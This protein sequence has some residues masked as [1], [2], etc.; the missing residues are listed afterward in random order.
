VI[1]MDFAER[2]RAADACRQTAAM[3]NAGR[4]SVGME[5]TELAGLEESGVCDW[6][7]GLPVGAPRKMEGELETKLDML[8]A[9]CEGMLVRCFVY[10]G[11]GG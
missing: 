7:A 9:H 11:C 6:V 10:G 1:G 2:C 5:L 8:Q 4:S 3:M